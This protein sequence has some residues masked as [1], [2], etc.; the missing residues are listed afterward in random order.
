MDPEERIDPEKQEGAQAPAPDSLTSHAADG[1]PSEMFMAM[2][3]RA[4]EIAIQA[5]VEAGTKTAAERLERERK[6]QAK[7][8]YDRR[9]HNTRI[10]MRNYRSLKEHARGAV[11]NSKKAKENPIDILDGLDHFE[12]TDNLYIESIKESKQRTMIIL[13]HI[14]KMMQIYEIAC[15]RSR[16]PEDLRRYRILYDYYCAEPGKSVQEISADY[17]EEERTIYKDLQKAVR[18]LSALI[19][20]IDGI[21][22]E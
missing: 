3:T 8:R 9:I 12:Y 11:M 10:L 4:T 5:G 1:I 14:D 13:T 7:S 21:Q 17:G 16:K 18:P 20:G 22:M 6:T 19:F 2:C 15:E